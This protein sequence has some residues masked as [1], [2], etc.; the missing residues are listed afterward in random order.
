[1]S[2]ETHAPTNVDEEYRSHVWHYRPNRTAQSEVHEFPHAVN[3]RTAENLIAG[4]L[5][6]K[7][8][9]SEGTVGR[10]ELAPLPE[11]PEKSSSKD[12]DA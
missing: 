10:N 2:N 12:G 5:G 11:K 8:L 1:M 4:R 6:L 3:Q 7:A 9:P